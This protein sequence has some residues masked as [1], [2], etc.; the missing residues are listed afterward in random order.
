[1]LARIDDTLEITFPSTVLVD[2]IQDYQG[3]LNVGS[4]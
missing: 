4:R 1:M 2:F 3:N